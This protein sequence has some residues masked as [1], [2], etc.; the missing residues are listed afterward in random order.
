[1]RFDRLVVLVQRRAAPDAEVE[2]FGIAAFAFEV[3][4]EF[5]DRGPGLLRAVPD[6]RDSGA[7]PVCVAGDR[8]EELRS[9]AEA[10]E[11]WLVVAAVSAD[12][13]LLEL[14]VVAVEVDGFLAVPDGVVG[15]E[16]VFQ[17]RES[18]GAFVPEG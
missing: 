12:P 9:A 11:A 5:G 10:P 2:G 17:P 1:R 6:E 16:L 4:F 14:E 18:L 7:Q 15:A 3:L 8:V 13:G